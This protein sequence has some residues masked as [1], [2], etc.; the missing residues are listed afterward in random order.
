MGKVSK[1]HR[2]LTRRQMMDNRRWVAEHASEVADYYLIC[3]N[4]RQTS[5]KFNIG[6]HHAMVAIYLTGHGD[7]LTKRNYGVIDKHWRKYVQK[8][9]LPKPG[10]PEAVTPTIKPI[11]PLPEGITPSSIALAMIDELIRLK[12]EVAVLEQIGSDL[13][14]ERDYLKQILEEGKK[15]E[16]EEFKRKLDRVVDIHSKD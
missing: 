16:M 2:E 5:K 14:S 4:V 12:T 8:G 1:V 10:S 7:R 9:L 6:Y 3:G 13:K 11:K 15:E